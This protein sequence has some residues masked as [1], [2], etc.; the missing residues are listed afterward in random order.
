M[1]LSWLALMK[2][3]YLITTQSGIKLPVLNLKCRIVT[4]MIF[5]T[6][7]LGNKTFNTGMR[8]TN[9]YMQNLSDP[10]EHF[11]FAQSLKPPIDKL[12]VVQKLPFALFTEL[13]TGNCSVGLSLVPE[14]PNIRWWYLGN[15]FS[16]GNSTHRFPISESQNQ[17]IDTFK[18]LHKVRRWILRL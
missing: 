7:S 10:T 17:S 15:V 12:G 16:G 8:Q 5:C 18:L 1:N 4:A 9:L 13:K 11:T 6:V 3:H 2:N 14:F